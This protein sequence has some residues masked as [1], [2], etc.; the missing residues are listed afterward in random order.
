MAP[1]HLDSVSSRFLQNRR[2]EKMIQGQLTPLR[3]SVYTIWMGSFTREGE[4]CSGSGSGTL[5]TSRHW[6]QVI[7]RNPSHFMIGYHQPPASG[8]LIENLYHFTFSEDHFVV[9]LVSF[10]RRNGVERAPGP[11]LV[12]DL[13][14]SFRWARTFNFVCLI[15]VVFEGFSVIFAD[16]VCYVFF[17]TFTIFIARVALI[18]VFLRFILTIVINVSFKMNTSFLRRSDEEAVQLVLPRRRTFQSLNV[19]L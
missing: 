7:W 5:I 6:I 9:G 3:I 13:S 12:S 16:I 1:N 19:Y 10:V 14:L 8:A 18:R 15:F 2:T 11:P 4:V 17:V